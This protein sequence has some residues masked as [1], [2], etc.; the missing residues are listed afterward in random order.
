LLHHEKAYY[1]RLTPAPGPEREWLSRECFSKITQMTGD[2]MSRSPKGW[3][4]TFT[5]K[6]LNSYFAEYFKTSGQ[7]DQMLPEGVTEP[8]VS[9]EDGG[10]IRLGFRYG[11]K[12]WDTLISIAFRVWLA[13]GE[14]N[15]LCMELMSLHAGGLPISAQSLLEQVFEVARR[16][17]IA[18][19]WYCYHGHHTAVL[20]IQAG[21]LHPTDQLTTLQISNGSLMIGGKPVDTSSLAT[22][23][24]FAP[25]LP[26]PDHIPAAR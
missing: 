19:T 7:S 17:N 13:N 24:S 25:A 14:L 22:A 1:A 20:R 23:A 8:R 5:E 11:K 9:L 16:S 15:A 18:V 4:Q 12:P 26:S 3:S 10:I 21:T 6:E 2:I